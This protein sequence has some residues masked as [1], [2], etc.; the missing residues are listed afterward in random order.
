M[1]VALVTGLGLGVF[2]AA[3]VGPIWLLC[4]RSSLR[5]GT[6][7]GLAIGAGAAVVA[8]AYAALG[9]A[10]AAQLVRI[11]AARLTLGLLGA[12]FLVYLGVRTVWQAARVRLGGEVEGEVLRPAAAFRT[13][14]AATA[15]N[16]TTIASWAAIFSAASV[17]NVAGSG[18]PAVALML[19]GIG[20][21]SFA[22]FAILA[23]LAGRF[24]R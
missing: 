5:F 14:L 13:S 11:D 9:V 23:G 17:G 12:A 10:G 3:Q 16:P 6:A 21:G 18:P 8:L 20:V 22:W 15:S 19:L 4:A 2:V 7:S 1:G 24:G